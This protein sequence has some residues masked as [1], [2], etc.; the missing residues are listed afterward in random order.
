MYKTNKTLINNLIYQL[1]ELNLGRMRCEIHVYH[2][3]STSQGLLNAI[4]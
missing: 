1:S 4:N 2:A 3:G